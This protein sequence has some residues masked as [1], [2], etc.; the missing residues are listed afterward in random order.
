MKYIK[1]SL[2]LSSLTLGA[3]ATPH[4]VDVVKPGDEELSCEQLEAEIAEADKFI[5]EAEAEKG[6]TGDNVTRAFFFPIGIWATYENVGEAIDAANQRK[7]YL[8]GI[9]RD[10]GCF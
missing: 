3:C 1:W 8:R 2:I 9:M 4:V 7:V 5:E 10:K 6:V